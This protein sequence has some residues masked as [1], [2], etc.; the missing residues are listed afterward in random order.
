MKKVINN[1]LGFI[2]FCFSEKL[3]LISLIGYILILI[4]PMFNWYSSSLIY[5]G[6]SEEFSYNM[7]Q[8]SSGQI[9]EKSYIALGIFII[10][11]S[12]VFIAIEYLNYKIKLRE[13]LP[14]VI[15]AE[16]FFYILLVVFV[17][18]ALNNDSL[19]QNMS[20][21][22]GEIE[23]MEYWIKEAE[24]HCNNGAGPYIYIAGLFVAVMSKVGVYIYYFID[25]V[26]DSLTSKKA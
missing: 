6:V 26:K 12:C 21:R 19:R 22:R 24:G 5:T 20:Y 4:S 11:I 1:I 13:R 3:V 7:F 23:A 25:N 2:G 18:I 8:L 10:L 17:I 16:I 9:K 15:P 14:I